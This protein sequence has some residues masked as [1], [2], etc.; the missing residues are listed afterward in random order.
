MN[1]ERTSSQE[2]DPKFD[3]YTV[4]ARQ[5]EGKPNCHYTSFTHLQCRLEEQG[6]NAQLAKRCQRLKKCFR[7]CGRSF[8]PVSTLCLCTLNLASRQRKEFFLRVFLCIWQN[9]TLMKS[10]WSHQMLLKVNV[11]PK[12]RQLSVV[13]VL[14]A[15]PI[16]FQHWM[17]CRG[18]EEVESSLEEFIDHNYRPGS[19]QDMEIHMR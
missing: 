17:T 13:F 16:N 12:R 9:T 14:A 19:S 1:G 11:H 18:R 2:W 4:Q 8:S 15:L 5:D 10:M 3:R 7:D 6:G